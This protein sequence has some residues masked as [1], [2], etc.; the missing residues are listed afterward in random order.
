M[1]LLQ[2]LLLFLVLSISALAIPLLGR[3]STFERLPDQQMFNLY[4]Q[5]GISSQPQ[6]EKFRDCGLWKTVDILLKYRLEQA[7]GWG[8]GLT[9]S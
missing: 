6:Q 1:L 8:M 2:V 7:L 9:E 5:S 4:S 3:R